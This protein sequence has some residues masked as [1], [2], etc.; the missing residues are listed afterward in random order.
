[1]HPSST[2]PPQHS[3]SKTLSTTC[4]TLPS[5]R[6]LHPTASPPT[7]A[8]RL[9]AA[10]YTRITGKRSS[11][12]L[13]LSWR[14]KRVRLMTF[15]GEERLHSEENRKIFKKNRLCPA[16]GCGRLYSSRISLRAHIRKCHGEEMLWEEKMGSKAKWCFVGLLKAIKMLMK[17]DEGIE[18]WGGRGVCTGMREIYVDK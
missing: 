16:D 1:M 15:R 18:V 13:P 17:V 5:F 12:P 14:T 4:V 10:I 6:C 7:A 8:A 2:T 3:L 9:I 11:R